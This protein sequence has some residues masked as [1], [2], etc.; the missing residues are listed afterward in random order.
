[1]SA[2]GG[3]QTS[4]LALNSGPSSL[5]DNVGYLHDLMQYLA[6]SIADFQMGSITP[7][8]RDVRRAFER[9]RQDIALI[10]REQLGTLVGRASLQLDRLV[11]T[12]YTGSYRVISSYSGQPFSVR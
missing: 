7:V 2:L 12:I 10:K 4:Q 3:K 5:H 6:R 1:M 8:Q 11:E 9:L